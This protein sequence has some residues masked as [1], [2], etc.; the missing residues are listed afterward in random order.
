[1]FRSKARLFFV[2]YLAAWV[3]G[4]ALVSVE[5]AMQYSRVSR[6]H[7]YDLRQWSFEGRLALTSAH[8]SWSANIS[9]DHNAATEKI[10]LSGPLGQGTV[11][12]Q[13]S[14]QTVSVDHGDGKVE[15]SAEP[16]QFINQQLGMFVPLHSLRYWV[17]GL[18][19][20]VKAFEE[21]AS[22]F[23]QSGWISEYK[24]MQLAS[25]ETMPRKMTVVNEQVKV[26]LIIDQWILHDGKAN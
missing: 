14:D 26:K 10:K 24:E 2:V 8:D 21:T 17:I 9:W 23:K 20:P 1:V 6:E 25:N 18:P 7:L 12:I 11:L 16:E 3:S 13:L 19:E 15:T 4:C 22:G 5:P